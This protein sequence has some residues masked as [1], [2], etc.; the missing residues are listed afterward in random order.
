MELIKNVCLQISTFING[1]REEKHNSE[2]VKPLKSYLRYASDS[3]IG[4]DESDSEEIHIASY[5]EHVERLKREQIFNNIINNIIN[6]NFEN[7]THSTHSNNS[8]HDADETDKLITK[9]SNPNQNQNPN[10]NPNH[11]YN[12]Q[13]IID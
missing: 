9:K 13:N 8:D 6:D 3:D 10:P 2:E 4:S 12:Y 5:E 11:N 1:N 7:S